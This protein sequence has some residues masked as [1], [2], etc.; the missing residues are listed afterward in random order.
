MNAKTAREVELERVHARI[1]AHLR[2]P[3]SRE[4]KTVGS[5]ACG[6]TNRHVYGP[7]GMLPWLPDVGLVAGL[8]ILRVVPIECAGCGVVRFYNAARFDG[9]ERGD[10][11]VPPKAE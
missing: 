4:V 7:V 2:K 10:G 1:Q 6:A 9:P 3:V 8:P 11:L 5:C